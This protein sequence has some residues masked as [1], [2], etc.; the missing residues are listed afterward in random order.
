VVAVRL[1]ARPAN[2]V[3][4]R[5]LSGAIGH[6]LPGAYAMAGYIL[7][8]AI[9][10]QDALAEALERAWAARPKL[11]DTD[12][13]GA[14]FGRIVVGVC[15]T[16][17][18]KRSGSHVGNLNSKADRVDDDDPFRASLLRDE[19]GRAVLDLAVDERIVT[20][21]SYWQRLSDSGIGATLGLR[22]RAVRARRRHALH[23][24]A[25]LGTNRPAPAL[26]AVEVERRLESLAA[27]AARPDVPYATVSKLTRLEAGAVT[28]DVPT[29]IRT[30][31]TVRG[32]PSVSVRRMA[33]LGLAA[34]VALAGGLLYNLWNYLPQN[35]HTPTPVPSLLQAPPVHLEGWRQVHAF[36][37]KNDQYEA[38]SLWWEDGQ[39]VGL[40][41][42]M[43]DTGTV[44]SCV[45]RSKDGTDWSCGELP[46]PPDLCRAQPC[47]TLSG[48]A[49]H[50][51]RWVTVGYVSASESST[52]VTVTWTS[53]DAGTWAQPTKPST[54]SPS[55]TLAG[56]PPVQLLATDA[57]F[58][59]SAYGASSALWTSADGTTWKPAR[60]SAGSW[61]MVRAALGTSQSGG[62]VADGECQV[63]AATRPCVAYSADG[64]MW[65]TA[66]PLAGASSDLAASLT[67][68]DAGPTFVGGRWNVYLST[69]GSG[70]TGTQDN[71]MAYAA[72]SSDGIHWTLSRTSPADWL[73]GGVM[74][75]SGQVISDFPAYSQLGN[76]GYW[77][78]YNGPMDFMPTGS[79]QYWTGTPPTPTTYWSPSGL[80]WQQIQDAPPGVPLA[81]VETP[82]Q[83][84]AI[85]AVYP[86]GDRA[87]TPVV[88][89][90]AAA[91]G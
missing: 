60:F 37:G 58:L 48:V 11:R 47:T 2:L 54:F 30:R 81:V 6:E 27:R 18:S 25:R 15:R 16:R 88:S 31:R 46:R 34:V 1:A 39:I 17:L 84:V 24:L 32:A 3:A 41:Q 28:I 90:W 8:D 68:G 49:F 57:G 13:V 14:W 56:R 83:L 4:D 65:T 63:G 42:G 22:E 12:A 91:K 38:V 73:V 53:S 50:N 75:S 23:A 69:S 51:G 77:A 70:V 20:V 21:L 5:A 36:A 61:S 59:L 74:D 64:S 86:N 87:A 26:S 29:S 89:V 80:Y 66:D 33:L 55:A 9:D 44:R 78:L 67:I 85:V 71:S 82:T 52:E 40:A 7:A 76:S 62:Y 79:T 45:L 72:R 43:D 35:N 10:A 19:I